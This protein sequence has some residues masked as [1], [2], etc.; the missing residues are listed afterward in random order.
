[1]KASPLELVMLLPEYT[2]HQYKYIFC[3]MGWFASPFYSLIYQVSLALSHGFTN[4]Q[5][6][7]KSGASVALLTQISVPCTQT[8]KYFIKQPQNLTPSWR[9]GNRGTEKNN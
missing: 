1:M 3:K 9:W 6:P 4:H 8:T 5:C 2:G 7:L